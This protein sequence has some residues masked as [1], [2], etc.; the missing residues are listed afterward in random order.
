[1]VVQEDNVS[2]NRELIMHGISNT[3]S[4]CVGSIQNY[5]VFVNSA[6]FMNTGADSRLAGYMLAAA[7]F[8]LWVAGPVVIGFVPVMVVGT[9]IYQLGIDLAQEALVSTWGRLH[10]LEYCTILII[11]LVMGLYDFVV[12]IAIGIGLACLVYVVQ[13]SR[14]NTIRAEFSG[15][16]AESTVRRHPRAKK[17]LQKVAHQVRIVKLSSYLFFG[18]I[19]RVEKKIRSV[20]DAEAFAASPIRYLILDFTHVSGI[21]FSAAEAFLR[22]NRI[23]HKREVKL[24]MAGITLGGDVGRSLSM[25]RI[26]WISYPLQS[27]EGRHNGCN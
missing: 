4:G 25:V 17:Y 18:S 20:V 5:L 21:D 26:P 15:A 19:V 16:V 2:I 1:M 24:S 12:G 27:A 22:M 7:T 10:R 8:G 23:L 6:L 13:T 14:T 9:L 3:L 11:A